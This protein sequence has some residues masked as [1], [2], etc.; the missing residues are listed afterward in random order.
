MCVLKGGIATSMLCWP[1]SHKRT[2]G[3]KIMAVA[4][5]TLAWLVGSGCSSSMESCRIVAIPVAGEAKTDLL[6][7]AA[8]RLESPCRVL[9]ASEIRKRIPRGVRSVLASKQAEVASLLREGEKMYYGTD[10]EEGRRRLLRVWEVVKANPHLLPSDPSERKGVYNSLLAVLQIYSSQDAESFDKMA[11]WLAVHMPDMTPS[12]KWLPPVPAAAASRAV[13]EAQGMRVRISS[14]VPASCTSQAVLH[15]DGLPIGVLPVSNLSIVA[16]TH[17]LHV[18]CEG[19]SSWARSLEL[20][21]DTLL[22]APDM[23]IEPLVI[24]TSDGVA[25]LPGLKERDKA[26]LGLRMARWLDVDGVALVP[27]ED[28]KAAAVIATPHRPATLVAP[29]SGGVYR[30][31]ESHVS[32]PFWTSP[33]VTWGTLGLSAVLTGCGVWAAERYNDELARMRFGLLDTRPQAQQWKDLSV[34][35]YTGA[36]VFLAAFGA[37]AALDLLNEPPPSIFPNV[38]TP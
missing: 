38:T 37:L 35:C 13:E 21:D 17:S 6:E 3:L 31:E 10:V 1:C 11:R 30:V 27:I 32:P 33:V 2:S 34:G 5:V 20:S 16:G 19:S 18:S 9:P 14:P 24:V 4:A 29:G 15:A 28:P 25:I 26:G 23:S 7:Q 12:I 22:E 36:A 8:C